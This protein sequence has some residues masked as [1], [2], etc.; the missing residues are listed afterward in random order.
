MKFKKNPRDIYSKKS[1][2]RNIEK[3]DKKAGK[4][5]VD[6]DRLCEDLH[7]LSA[8]LDRCCSGKGDLLEIAVADIY[9][10]REAV[11]L[12]Q[13]SLK[14]VSHATSISKDIILRVKD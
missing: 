9:S 14:K 2:I 10:A 5:F 4:A 3:T 13:E 7:T 1:I 11:L 6:L 12:A 8:I